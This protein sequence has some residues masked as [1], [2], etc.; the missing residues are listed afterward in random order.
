MIH[1]KCFCGSYEL[2]ISRQD[3]ETDTGKLYKDLKTHENIFFFALGHFGKFTTII[4]NLID[5]INLSQSVTIYCWR[6]DRKY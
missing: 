3:V 1:K 2:K 4:L 5:K 6:P